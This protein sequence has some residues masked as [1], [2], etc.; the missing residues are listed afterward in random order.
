M[1]LEKSALETAKV[2]KSL[3][4]GL[5]QKRSISFRDI[6]CS[7][8]QMWKQVLYT[9]YGHGLDVFNISSVIKLNNIKQW[10]VQFQSSNGPVTRRIYILCVNLWNSDES[11]SSYIWDVME[12]HFIKFLL[13]Y[14][15]FYAF[16]VCLF[17]NSNFLFLN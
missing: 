15:Q 9:G 7:W 17:F 8:R 12:H 4:Y 5:V 16:F 3:C 1:A 11:F 13:D 10:K 2:Y 6:L 14:S